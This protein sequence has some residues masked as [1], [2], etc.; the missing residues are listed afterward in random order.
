MH[1]FHCVGSFPALRQQP[2]PTQEVFQGASCEGRRQG[3]G[4][5]RSWVLL[6]VLQGVSRLYE[7][8]GNRLYLILCASRV[9]RTVELFTGGTA[10]RAIIAIQGCQGV[11]PPQRFWV[12][13]PKPSKVLAAQHCDALQKEVILGREDGWGGWKSFPSC[14]PYTWCCMDPS[15]PCTVCLFW[16]C[17]AAP[18]SPALG[19]YRMGDM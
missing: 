16:T 11:L 7:S 9:Q 19:F 12:Q 3:E 17:P 8:L 2:F 18:C 13:S 14:L 5:W 1:T 6:L 15:K 4:A 10:L